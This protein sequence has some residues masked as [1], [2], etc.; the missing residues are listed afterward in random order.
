MHLL[1]WLL[2]HGI[3]AW[4]ASRVMETDPPQNGAASIA[5][6]FTGA[7][8]AGWLLGSATRNESDF[9]LAGLFVSFMGAVTLLGL[10]NVI[11]ERLAR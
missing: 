10:A 3:L 4:I 6:G 5:L 11:R 9:T 7:S 1:V 8:L 2:I